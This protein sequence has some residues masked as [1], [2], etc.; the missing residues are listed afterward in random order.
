MRVLRWSSSPTA[1]QLCVSL[2]CFTEIL[3]LASILHLARPPLEPSACLAVFAS[4]ARCDV[5]WK[6]MYK[7]AEVKDS[8]LQFLPREEPGA[9]AV[10]G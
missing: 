8:P 7:L 3:P 2:L 6:E 9:D 1:T 5:S 4:A 10:P